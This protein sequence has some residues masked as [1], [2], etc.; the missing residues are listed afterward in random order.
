MT[1]GLNKENGSPSD[2][3]KQ[4]EMERETLSCLFFDD[5]KSVAI[6][7]AFPPLGMIPSEIGEKAPEIAS[8]VFIC[9]QGQALVRI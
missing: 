4:K 6:D 1:A 9:L 5:E 7:F 3:G 2:R 8:I